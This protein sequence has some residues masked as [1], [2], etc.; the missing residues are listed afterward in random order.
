MNETTIKKIV[1]C[2]GA[3]CVLSR[4]KYITVQDDSPEEWSLGS[5]LAL[6]GLG[7][8]IPGRK[9]STPTFSPEETKVKFAALYDTPHAV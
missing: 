1:L 6:V 2:I 4:D 3:A 7:S 5:T 9:P 8:I